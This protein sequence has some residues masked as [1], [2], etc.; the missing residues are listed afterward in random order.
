[1]QGAETCAA[2][3]CMPGTSLNCD[4]D[5]ECTADSCAPATGC[6]HT[7][8]SG[9]VPAFT[10]AA[11]KCQAALA[12]G[13]ARFIRDMHRAFSSCLDTILS[14][15]SGTASAVG[16]C[17]TNLDPNDSGSRASRARTRATQQITK[18]CEGIT[19]GDINT[20]C[21]L[22]AVTMTETIACVLDQHAESVQRMIAAEY[23]DACAMLPAVGLGSVFP[24]VCA[25]P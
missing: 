8:V 25:A 23:R 18:K 4:D 20:P 1:M 19:P 15:G 16:C 10:S 13:G 9:C 5:D 24:D 21:A 22:G 6:T 14:E 17:S 12:K 2:G 7:P 11:R 3:D